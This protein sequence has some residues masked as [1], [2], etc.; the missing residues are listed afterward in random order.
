ML[1]NLLQQLRDFWVEAPR[2]D[3]FGMQLLSNIARF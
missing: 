1:E 2:R 3:R